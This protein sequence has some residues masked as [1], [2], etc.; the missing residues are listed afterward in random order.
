MHYV[1][2][3]RVEHDFACSVYRRGKCPV[4]TVLCGYTCGANHG[5]RK[6]LQIQQKVYFLQET[7]PEISLQ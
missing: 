7:R 4:L 5:F 1:D 3:R 2:P 6:A